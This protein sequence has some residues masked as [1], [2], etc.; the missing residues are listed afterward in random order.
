MFYA[1]D[2]LIVLMSLTG[3]EDDVALLSHHTGCANGFATVYDGDDLLHLF[4][5]KSSQHIIDNVLWFLK[6][7]IV[8]G[9]D[10]TVALLH[11]FLC[12]QRALTLVAVATGTTDGDDLSFSVQHFMYGV[13]HVYQGIRCMGIVNDGRIAFRRTDGVK[14][15]VDALEGTHDNKDILRLLAQHNSGSIDTEQ[16]GDIELS[17]KLHAHLTAV[18]LEVHPLEMTLHDASTEVGHLPYTVGLYRCLRILYHEQTVLVV[19]IGDDKGILIK[20]VEERLLGI[21]IVLHRL[22]IVQM[23]AR[24]VREESPGK[25]QTANALLRDSMAGALHEHILT[26]SI[27]HA[28]QQ[29]I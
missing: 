5:V 6:T 15:T 17:D 22:M 10:D 1:L 2:F 20:A 25:L 18:N 27:G 19:S 23:V 4:L 13:Q 24:E 28:S 21:A 9:D 8:R 12:H 16:I 26:T 14:A 3:N 11:G 29:L 7:R